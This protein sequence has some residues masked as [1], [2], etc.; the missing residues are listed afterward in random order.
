MSHRLCRHPYLVEV[1]ALVDE[2]EL[3]DIAPCG[4]PAVWATYVNRE[5][6]GQ[7]IETVTRQ[8]DP[9]DQLARS[10]VGYVDSIRLL[11]P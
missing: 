1:L 8:C 9:H 7:D 4:E 2:V 6:D 10:S 5:R 11:L 3:G